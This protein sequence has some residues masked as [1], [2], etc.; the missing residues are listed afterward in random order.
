MK[1]RCA[2]FSGGRIRN[3]YTGCGRRIALTALSLTTFAA[4]A[5]DRSGP[6]DAAADKQSDPVPSTTKH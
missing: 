5:A 6:A 1:D 3:V 2:T 4:A